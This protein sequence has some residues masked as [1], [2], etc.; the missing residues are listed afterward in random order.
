MRDE[1]R[2][3]KLSAVFLPIVRP[4]MK[5]Q[6]LAIWKNWFVTDDTILD[7]K[8]PGKMKSKYNYITYAIIKL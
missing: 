3:E 5:D 1:T 6:F 4:G 7:E 2:H 8:T